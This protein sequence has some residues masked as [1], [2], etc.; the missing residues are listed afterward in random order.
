MFKILS[1]I[2]DTD[3]QNSH[4]FVYSSYS[5]PDYSDRRTGRELWWAN[6]EFSPAGIISMALHAH[7]SLQG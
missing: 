3:M 1:R 5:L 4:S 2:S 6:Q 7:I